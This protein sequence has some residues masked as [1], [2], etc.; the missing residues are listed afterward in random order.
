MSDCLRLALFLTG[1]RVASVILWLTW[2]WFTRRSLSAS[3]VRWLAL[4]SY[5]PLLTSELSYEWRMPNDD[6]RMDWTPN[7]NSLIS[8][9]TCRLSLYSLAS[10]PMENTVFS[11]RVL[12]C[13]QAASCS[14]VHRE[15]SSCCFVFAGTCMLS[16][17]LAM[18]I[19]VTIFYS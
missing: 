4:H 19:F 16:R 18:V 7:S 14:T 1:L 10:D 3:V 2:F 8:L 17:C 11:C 15:H 5:S 13:Y 12:L 6:S 9:A